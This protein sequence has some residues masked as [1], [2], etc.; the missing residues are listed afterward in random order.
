MMGAINHPSRQPVPPAAISRV[1]SRFSR[2][3][4]EGF[5]AVAIDLLDLM[6]GDPDLEDNH[7]GDD[8]GDQ[9]WIEWH[10]ARGSQNI[11]PGHEDDEDAD[12]AEDGD[13]D[14]CAAG[15]DRLH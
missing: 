6:D 13:S 10:M 15:D 11:L 3:E 8:Q 14:C 1:L 7:D 5:V 9:S 4:L 2:S 12:P